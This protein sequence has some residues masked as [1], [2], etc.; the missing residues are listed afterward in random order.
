MVGQ[1]LPLQAA[2][3]HLADPEDPD[4]VESL[5][6]LAAVQDR[7]DPA[8]NILAVLDIL[9][10]LKE[11][12]DLVLQMTGEAAQEPHILLRLVQRNLVV[13]CLDQ[14]CS[15]CKGPALHHQPQVLTEHSLLYL[16][17]HHLTADY[18][19]SLQLQGHMVDT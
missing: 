12:A 9:L 11:V 2:L 17:R 19:P 16:E 7:P 18:N 6:D 14:A 4:L 13:E 5:A 15:G 10:G 1:P 3:L 8:Y